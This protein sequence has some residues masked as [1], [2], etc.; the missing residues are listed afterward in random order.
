MLEGF[1]EQAGTTVLL[2]SHSET[3]KIVGIIAWKRLSHGQINLEH[4]YAKKSALGAGSI[5]GSKESKVLA[6]NSKAQK[7]I[8]HNNS[9]YAIIQAKC[10]LFF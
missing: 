3:G 6:V 5:D 9:S 10:K 4:M 1:R 8:L 2:A 7:Y